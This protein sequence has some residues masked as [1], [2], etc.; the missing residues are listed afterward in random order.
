MKNE[1]IVRNS[2]IIFLAVVVL[3]VI[4][5]IP[6]W[7]A[8]VKKPGGIQ[9]SEAAAGEQEKV[10]TPENTIID[11]RTGEVVF[12]PEEDPDNMDGKD[13]IMESRTGRV[14]PVPTSDPGN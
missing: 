12:V 2:A 5:T 9:V 3:A 14:A 6:L 7:T 10:A 8:D 4:V 11:S 1:K 13:T